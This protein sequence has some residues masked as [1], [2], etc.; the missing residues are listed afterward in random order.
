MK[1]SFLKLLAGNFKRNPGRAKLG[2]YAEELVWQAFEDMPDEGFIDCHVHLM[3]MGT[4]GTGCWMNPGIRSWRHPLDHLKVMMYI[5]ASAIDDLRFADQQYLQRLFIQA[6]DLPYPAKLMLLALDGVYTKKGEFSHE[7]TKFYVPNDYIYKV[8]E[9]DPDRFIPCVSIHP[10]RKDA[11]EALEKWAKWGVRFVKWLPN[12]MGMDP[13][14]AQ[15]EPF[16]EKMREHD[17][18][19]LGYAGGESAIEVVKF[20]HLGNP[21]YYRKPL[22]MGVK[23]IIAHCA[24]LGIGID[25][26]SMLKK[27]TKNF[28][29]FLR[30]MEEKA[31]E[32]LLFA[33]ISAITQINRMG[34]PLKTMLERQELHHRLI[35]GSDYPLPAL[36]AVISTRALEFLG[37]LNRRE[38]V[39]L[40]QLYK[41]NPLLFDFVLKRTLK[42]PD[43]PAKKFSA[44]IFRDHPILDLTRVAAGGLL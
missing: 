30:L 40:N 10:Y 24:S 31:Y 9:S 43:D 5:N 15:C 42:H 26:E 39:A 3:G 4:G 22:E 44:S 13:S 8:F 6:D 33:D 41:R 35:N 36:N 11:V 29:L 16:Y 38:R 14:D 17:M 28:N 37:Y 18:V 20:K 32:G 2:W 23:V 19:L 7:D 27:P 12:V 25:V 1:Y 21:L 34:T